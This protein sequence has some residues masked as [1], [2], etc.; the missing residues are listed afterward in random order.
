MPRR[1]LRRGAGLQQQLSGQAVRGVALDHIERLV[2]GAADHGVKELERILAP[3][4][5]EPNEG[6]GGRTKPACL[7]SGEGGR[8][9]QRGPIAENR[10]RAQEGKRLR[11]EA[12]KTKPHDPRNALRPDLQQT[13]HLLGR[14]AGSLPSNRVEHRADE[15][16]ISASHRCDGGTEGIVR[17][18]TVQ[19]AREHGDRGPA[20][21]FGANRGG[22]RI[23]E[24]LCDERGIAALTLG[25]P[26]SGGD[27]KR[28]PLK[29]SRQVQEPPKRGG[30]RP[31][32]VVDR[33]KRWLLQGH[34]GGEP[35]EAVQN[36]ERA[37]RG[38]VLG[39]GEPRGSEQRFHKCRRPREQLRTEI[40]GGR[41]EQ[42]V[43]Q[44]ADDPVRKLAL[45]LAA[46]GSQH[47]HTRR[48]GNRARLGEQ[49]G[50]A[51]AGA[52]LDDDKPPTAAPRRV[53]QCLKRR[54]L[55]FALQEQGGFARRND[56]RRCH[57]DQSVE[58]SEPQF[59]GAFGVGPDAKGHV[60]VQSLGRDLSRQLASSVCAT[61]T[62][63]SPVAVPRHDGAN[64]DAGK[65][66]R[67]SGC[68]PKRL[69][70][71]RGIP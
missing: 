22:L 43:E 6:G 10:G 69:S 71:H 17:L 12:S 29:P 40:R 3:E 36:G 32:Q 13:G 30:V 9:A 7:H 44:F 68:P 14:W 31:V 61:S 49:A 48:A 70:N 5:P 11:L 50:L 53:G 39:S 20:E 35:I 28:H 1:T 4:K 38:R 46:A 23:G 27:E 58:P 57:H 33:E 47:T 51:D 37:L 65:R 52:S 8:L 21:R 25:R 16:R 55:G 2:D 59:R 67:D 56:T 41:R 26:G 54:D 60:R 24:E 63:G 15:E 34:V 66:N 19:L 64:A 42:G 45:Q 62:T 18:Q